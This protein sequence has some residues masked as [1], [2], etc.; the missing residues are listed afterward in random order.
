MAGSLAGAQLSL[1]CGG[2]RCSSCSARIRLQPLF[3]ALHSTSA[4]ACRI[5]SC[6]SCPSLSLFLTLPASAAM[7]H[8][9]GGIES[10][11]SN[12]FSCGGRSRRRRHPHSHTL[13]CATTQ[14]N[15]P[16]TTTLTALINGI[17]CLPLSFSLTKEVSLSLPISSSASVKNVPFSACSP[18][19]RL[20]AAA[21]LSAS[22][23][24]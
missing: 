6:R 13:S 14:R 7:I 21:R 2:R 20:L 4:T 12:R 18:A 22:D 16:L 10:S 5:L 9:H 1:R 23:C 24:H 15:S 17:D 19:L 3:P 11:T 8:C